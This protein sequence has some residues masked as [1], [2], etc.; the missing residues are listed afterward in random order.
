M[1][2]LSGAQ[3]RPHQRLRGDRQRIK[4]QRKEIPQLQHHLVRGDGGS[5]EPGGDGACRY[6]AGL[7]RHRA[8]QQIATHD[9]LGAQHR[10]LDPQ[11]H[12]LGEQR[13]QE[14][15]RGH[16]LPHQVGDRRTGQ[17]QPRHAEPAVHQQRAQ[18]G[19]HREP[20]DDVAQRP[21]GVLHATHPA[22]ARRRDQNRRHA[23]D[24]DANPRQ[25]G[26]G[27]IATGRQRRHQRHGD[28]LDHDDDQRAQAQRQPGGLH[29]FPDG[30][31]AIARAEEAGRACG[32][33]VG[34]EG[35]LRTERG[36]ESARRWPGR[37]A[38]TR[39]TVRRPRGRRADRS[40]RRPALP[41][42]ERPMRR[43]ACRWP[44]RPADRPPAQPRA[45]YSA[46]T[47]SSADPVAE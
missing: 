11:R 15:Q 24:R 29:P 25:R 17:L 19:R 45:V 14:Q 1:R 41:A 39:P 34:Q 7:E 27:D 40:V 36:S 32:G 28:D 2:K 23:N 12:P 21:S 22:V 10:R 30:R 26:S 20:R 8:Q 43:C 38:A 13:A 47:T 18:H 37:P 31:R 33:A 42:R 44:G 3:R 6:E 9:D 16:P 35:H 46:C 4:H 5:A